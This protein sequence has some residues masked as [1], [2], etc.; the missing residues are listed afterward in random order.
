MMKRSF[1]FLFFLFFLISLKIY[2]THIV[3]GELNY[4]YL[5]NNNYQIRLLVYR[6]CFNGIPPFDN[7]ASIGIFNSSNQLVEELLV[8]SIDG[9][10]IA[11]FINSP[12]LQPPNNICYEYCE[13]ID[14]VNLPPIPGGYQLAYQ[15]C[16]RNNSILNVYNV[17]NVGATY[18]ATIPDTSVVAINSNPRFINLPPTFICLG[19]PFHFDHSA[20]DSDGDSLVYELCTP[21]SGADP[22]NNTPQPPNPPPY[23]PIFFQSPYNLGNVMGGVPL[24]IDHSTG[25]LTATPNTLGQ[26]VYGVCVNE[27]RNGILIGK[28]SRDYQVNV[29]PCPNI[30]VAS[31]FSPTL[32]CGTLQADFINNSFNASTY[33]WDFGDPL[34]PNDTSSLMNPSYV[35][36]DTGIYHAMLIAHSPINPLCTD[37]AYSE[38]R[39][40]PAFFTVFN[41]AN[42]HCSNLYNFFD[43]SY[44]LHGPASF[45]QWNFGDGFFS[46]SQNPNH[47][48]ASGGQYNVTFISSADSGCTDTASMVIHVLDIPAISYTP[49]LDTCHFQIT[50]TNNTSFA[51]NYFW[52]LGDGF[53]SASPDVSHTYSIDGTYTID[54]IAVSD[55]GCSDTSHLQV[56]FPPLPVASYSYQH[57]HCES[58]VI[59]SNL[60]SNGIQYSWDF[61]DGIYSSNPDVIHSYNTPGIYSPSLVVSSAH[62][63]DTIVQ[64]VTID[65]IP[66]AAFSVPFACGLNQNFVNESS[67]AQFFNWNFGDGFFSSGFNAAH[68]YLNQGVYHVT[69]T[70]ITEVGCGDTAIQ[71][72]QVYPLTTAN[73]I[74]DVTPCSPVVSFENNTVN[75]V[76]YN[77]DFGDSMSATTQIINPIHIYQQAGD[78]IATLISNPGVCADTATQHFRVT[79]SPVASFNYPDECGLTSHFQNRSRDNIFNHWNFGDGAAS[80]ETSPIHTFAAEYT[81]AVTLIVENSDACIDSASQRVT[82]RLPAVA[83]Y[84]NFTDTCEDVVRLVNRSRRS[85]S[86]LWNFGDGNYSYDLNTE[87]HYYSSGL[88]EVILIADPNT[89]CAD[90]M[91]RDVYSYGGVETHLYIPNAFTPNG[92]GKNDKFIISG[93]N[94]CLLYHLTIFNRWGEKIFESNDITKPWDG[95]LNGRPVE[96]GSYVYLLTGGGNEILGQV[97][98][99]K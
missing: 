50:L 92:D 55:S 73:F 20:T 69:L 68:S 21:L 86:Y 25:M 28:T 41:T 48:Y 14:T 39:V 58:E 19:A 59:F 45:W 80:N 29:V 26:F 8:D 82:V 7:P 9:A 12:C 77:W 15:R 99:L 30:T 67:G 76:L 87:H 90:T 17:A 1:C 98:V 5:G 16:C 79:I 10:H 42:T 37:T 95:Y 53:F 2:A 65:T 23:S 85:A 32:V 36:P 33:N 46:S 34:N 51:S 93:Y 97:S 91:T 89:V 13:Y 66:V 57:H 52:S 38:V 43:A 70:V 74:P 27:Y 49:V 44:G 83:D 4:T 40:F 31:I 22:F 35:Y 72:I 56:S 60:S 61:G 96:E 71:D 78:Y 94:K 47:S 62:C 18:Y 84:L 6:D 3:G 54:L 11:N 88:Y 75:G 64:T 63:S 81:Y 24:M